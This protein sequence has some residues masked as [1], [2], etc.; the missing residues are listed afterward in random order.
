[1]KLRYLTIAIIALVLPSCESIPIT[2]AYK[3]QVAG[4]DV[5]AAYSKKDGVVVA[6]ERLRVQPQK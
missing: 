5:T 6:A 2:A 1:M 4:H 3:T